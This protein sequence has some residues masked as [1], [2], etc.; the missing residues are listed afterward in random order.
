MPICIH[1]NQL[2]EIK[3]GNTVCEE[4]VKTGDKWVHLRVC[5][6]CGTTLCCDSSVNQHARKHYTEDGHNIIASAEENERWL[7]CYEHKIIKKY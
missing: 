7:W 5:Q 2:K 1:L 6:D 4:C 3:T